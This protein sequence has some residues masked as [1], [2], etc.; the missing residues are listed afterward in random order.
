MWLVAGNK[1]CNT[2]DK[3]D[4][5]FNAILGVVGEQVREDNSCSQD[6]GLQTYHLN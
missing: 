2:S 4:A 5:P 1:I 3:Q 6:I